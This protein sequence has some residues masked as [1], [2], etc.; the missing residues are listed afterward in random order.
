M[1]LAGKCI[2]KHSFIDKFLA[3]KVALKVEVC[4]EIPVEISNQK[5]GSDQRKGIHLSF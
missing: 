2:Q 3:L 5:R 1:I 4:S